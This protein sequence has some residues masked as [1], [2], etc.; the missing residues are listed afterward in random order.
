MTVAEISDRTKVRLDQ[1][2]WFARLAK[3]RS[4][5][6]R[7]CT[8]GLVAVNGTAVHKPSH[9]VRVGDTIV[10]PQG[11]LRR[12]A[13]IV[14][15]SSRRGPAVEARRLYE[16]T[17]APVRIAELGPQWLALLDGALDYAPAQDLPGPMSR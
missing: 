12:T 8:A 4:L 2:L 16:E 1:W 3:S 7:L 14:A 11:R 10:L 15:I 9:T 5:A 17:A 13:R 6:A